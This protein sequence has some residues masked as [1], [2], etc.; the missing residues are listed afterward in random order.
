MRRQ[1]IRYFAVFGLGVLAG[2]GISVLTR[3]STRSLHFDR[4][5]LQFSPTR[6]PPLRLFQAEKA[7]NLFF[8]DP[9]KDREHQ[10][11]KAAAIEAKKDAEVSK[12]KD[13]WSPQASM[14][15]VPANLRNALKPSQN[16]WMV[17]AEVW[18]AQVYQCAEA[19]EM[20]SCSQCGQELVCF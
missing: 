15:N 18:A 1:Q 4:H 6:T 5:A 8:G 19:I 11:D 7:D 2:V 10:R 16:L 12:R 3:D 13:D 17:C 9:K 14:H 20:D